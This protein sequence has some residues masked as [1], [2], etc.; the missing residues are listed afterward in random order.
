MENWKKI[1]NL[2]DRITNLEEAL[3]VIIEKVE[4]M[5]AESYSNPENDPFALPNS[6]EA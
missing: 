2:E 5:W 1:S 3:L 6:E 4:K